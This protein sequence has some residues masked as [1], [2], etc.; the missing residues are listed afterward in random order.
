MPITIMYMYKCIFFLFCAKITVL[1][2]ILTNI[3]VYVCIIIKLVV[4]H[5]ALA[6]LVS[7]NILKKKS[8]KIRIYHI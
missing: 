7:E 8:N 1:D 4:M 2:S 5:I 3:H 6:T